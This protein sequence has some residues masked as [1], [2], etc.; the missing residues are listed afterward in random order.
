MLQF[1]MLLLFR[2]CGIGRCDSFTAIMYSRK[3]ILILFCFF[4]KNY[5]EVQIHVFKSKKYSK[6]SLW[7]LITS[8]IIIVVLHS[9]QGIS[10]KLE[11]STKTVIKES[12][13]S[14][15][16]ALQDCEELE[17]VGLFDCRYLSGLHLHH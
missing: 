10:P 9:L 17:R 4:Y 2:I 12:A 15:L 6:C 5:F 3:A 7:Y 16:D 13:S 8:L 14:A 11:F 1:Y